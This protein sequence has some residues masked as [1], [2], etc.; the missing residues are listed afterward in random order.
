MVTDEMLKI[1][2]EI[3]YVDLQAIDKLLVISNGDD[4]VKNV[5]TEI[6]ELFDDEGNL[7]STKVLTLKRTKNKE[8]DA[9]KYDT[10]NSMLSV[11]LDGSIE[12]D[13]ALG[14][15]HIMNDMPFNWV[16]AFNTLLK[17]GVLVSK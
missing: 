17:Y 3:F 16:L 6:E 7:V 12:V 14:F 9:V 2:G 4:D 10:I 8:I 15:A 13:N 5:E 11:V 1:G